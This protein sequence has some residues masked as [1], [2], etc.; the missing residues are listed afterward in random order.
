MSLADRIIEQS[1]DK[2]VKQT[3]PKFFNYELP[4]KDELGMPT[5]NCLDYLIARIL[6]VDYNLS[7]REHL[8]LRDCDD[9]IWEGNHWVAENDKN[10]YRLLK[11]QGKRLDPD[12]KAMVWA[13]LRE[14]IPTLSE[15][16]MVAKD[17]LIWDKKNCE[18]YFSDDDIL[19]IN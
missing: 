2:E 14:C 6:Y 11:W 3:K 19:T 12:Q 15:D 10:L 7:G 13:R 16:K 9:Y 5:A 8:H 1:F 18:L 4:E 17:N